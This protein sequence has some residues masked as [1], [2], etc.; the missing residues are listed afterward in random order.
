MSVSSCF[1]LYCPQKQV[2]TSLK[3]SKMYHT[4]DS[5]AWTV[6]FFKRITSQSDKQSA[7]GVPLALC[8]DFAHE[9][10]WAHCWGNWPFYAHLTLWSIRMWVEPQGG[11]TLETFFPVL[12]SY[13]KNLDVS[14]QA[15]QGPIW[16]NPPSSIFSFGFGVK[17]THINLNT[18]I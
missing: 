9:A 8:A 13:I 14:Q 18:Q 6:T 2:L 3:I 4:K 11:S 7:E 10:F 17:C 1:F 12:P 16:L 15:W 5:K